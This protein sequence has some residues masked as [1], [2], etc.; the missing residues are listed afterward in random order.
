MKE[1]IRFISKLNI[2][3]SVRIYFALLYMEKI[4]FFHL[5]FW[6]NLGSQVSEYFRRSKIN[7]IHIGLIF[8]DDNNK[9]KAC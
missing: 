8:L 6:E 3:S 9:V 5:P 1:K 2:E 4:T 7:F